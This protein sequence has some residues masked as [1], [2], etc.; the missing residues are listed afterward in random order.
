MSM[1]KIFANIIVDVTVD[2]LNKSFVYVVPE[3]LVGKVKPGDKV[4]FPF[5]RGNTD[6]EG[7]VLELLNLEQLKTKNFYKK[8]A[9][10]KR[11][12]AI[13]N[14]KEIKGI[15]KNKIAVSEILLKIAIF[16]CKEYYAPISACI[17]TVLPVKRVIRK[18]KKQVD[19]ISK[20]KVNESEK[21]IRDDI[22]LN[23]EQNKIIDDIVLEHKK[24]QYSEHLIF[25]V[26]GSGKTEVYIKVI[27]E[28]LK[29]GKQVIV[30]IPEIALTHQT[31][32]RLKEK[33]EDNIAIIHSRMSEGDRYI[34]YKKFKR[35]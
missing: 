34:Q 26:T 3:D 33:F 5:G 16:L 24:E 22:K 18:N 19:A 20:Y 25:G 14:L 15:S 23:N 35:T 28:V 30:L 10:F 8:E 21:V 29:E 17:N 11:A 2:A 9:Y 32:I 13:D 12:D 27:E 31:V 4:I 6:R 1:E 7:F